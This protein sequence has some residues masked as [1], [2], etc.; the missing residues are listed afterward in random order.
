MRWTLRE[1]EQ[2]GK[3]K[4]KEKPAASFPILKDHNELLGTKDTTTESL[5]HASRNN[6]D[7][8]ENVV[9]HMH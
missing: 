4:A 2:A 9:C 1:F 5:H 6:G 7:G 3:A 8:A